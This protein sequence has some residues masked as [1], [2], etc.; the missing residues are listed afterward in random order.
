MMVSNWGLFVCYWLWHVHRTSQ[1]YKYWNVTGG[2]IPVFGDS[3][4]IQWLISCKYTC[5]IVYVIR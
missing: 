3:L 1:L 4:G 2:K 5:E